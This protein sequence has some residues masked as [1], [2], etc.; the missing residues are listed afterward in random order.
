MLI[1]RAK[2]QPPKIGAD[3]LVR[4]R[5]DA[6]L[7]RT[8]DH[9]LTLIAAPAG[10][11]KTTA[12]RQWQGIRG[13]DLRWMTIDTD[14]ADPERFVRHIVAALNAND[15]L[16]GRNTID[17]LEQSSRPETDE[18]A[19][20]LAD[21][22]FD[23]D[24][25]VVLVLDECETLSAVES[26][27]FVEGLL[28][29]APESLHIVC[30]TRTD[31]PLSLG[32]LR[33]RGQLLELRGDTLQFEE[34]ETGALLELRTGRHDPELA[35][36]L[37][38]QTNGW[39]AA[40]TLAALAFGSDPNRLPD[41]FLLTGHGPTPALA[42]AQLADEVLT[43]F[44][45][46]VRDA[47]TL[48]TILDTVTPTLMASILD[49]PLET[50]DQ[51]L[52]SLQRSGLLTSRA[53]AEG[54][55]YQLHPLFRQLFQLEVAH[56]E[57]PAAL[58]EWHARA[59]LALEADGA[60][61]P[62]VD[63]W[64]RA[65]NQDR[66][67]RLLEI[68][69]PE[70]FERAEWSELADWLAGLPEPILMDRPSLA[71]GRCWTLFT[72]GQM[73]ALSMNLQR[74]D[75]ILATDRWSEFDKKQWQPAFDV[76]R[77]FGLYLTNQP[78]SDVPQDIEAVAQESGLGSSLVRGY[79]EFQHAWSL[80]TA[81]RTDA[82]IRYADDTIAQFGGTIDAAYGRAVITRSLVLRQQGAIPAAEATVRANIGTLL[83]H[84][85]V[86]PSTWLHL[87]LGWFA[88]QRDDLGTAIDELHQVVANHR[89]AY[90]LAVREAMNL[91]AVIRA[92]RGE[93]VE[94]EAVMRRLQEILSEVGATE[95]MP[96]VL[97][98]AA[99]LEQLAGRQPE[100]NVWA[101]SRAADVQRATTLLYLHPATVR[102]R[103][104]IG[105]DTTTSLESA[106]EEIASF[107]KIVASTRCAFREPELELLRGCALWRLGREDEALH[108]LSTALAHPAARYL[109][110]EFLNSAAEVAPMLERLDPAEE[111][112]PLISYLRQRLSAE[113]GP[114]ATESPAVS[115]SVRSDAALVELLTAREYSVL[116]GLAQR[117]SYKEIAEQLN[118]SPLT[119]KR[120]ANGLYLKLAAGNR[121]EAVARAMELGF[122]PDRGSSQA[123]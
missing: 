35:S 59:A 121:R 3:L 66:A 6:T 87:L 15:G 97:M 23:R 77:N 117:L 2:L 122:N 64:L 26:W 108:A 1:Q 45:A 118:I 100:S 32:R 43:G 44:D 9:R 106:L 91:L 116:I 80:Q 5:I 109:P 28:A 73:S 74:V 113:K 54:V 25:Q 69:I 62:A 49:W 119:V 101:G 99:W 11:G 14:D 79:A 39:A 82:A 8:F 48:A 61:R 10:Y 58:R 83:R 17:L 75:S 20:V 72:R 92:L 123:R 63:Q 18:L 50:C 24:G 76:L 57:S 4:P 70:V 65:G 56:R 33:L 107:Q 34:H 22:L 31:P 84:E 19:E 30:I 52:T 112:L 105:A 96:G 46:T 67:L 115:L 40:I 103:V 12:V 7:D 88:Y 81:G 78:P 51:V 95:L 102:I 94:S 47:L 37:Q 120:H 86:T 53:W 90:A 89:N 85:V 41:V 71:F 68:V 27:K 29:H 42:L 36:G 60:T 16:I 114:Q 98:C 13:V 110:R 38:H 104:L 111:T 21:E 93:W 55:R